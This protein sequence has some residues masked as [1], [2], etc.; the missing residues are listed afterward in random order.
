MMQM[1]YSSSL[2][3]LCGSG[4]WG[5][6][7]R[8]VWATPVERGWSLISL[9]VQAIRF[10]STQRPF[11]YNELAVLDLR[12]AKLIS[13]SPIDSALDLVLEMETWIPA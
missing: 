12:S 11:P 3:G 4:V 10:C 13:R 5:V 6:R 7:L 1:L 9:D 8:G 2:E